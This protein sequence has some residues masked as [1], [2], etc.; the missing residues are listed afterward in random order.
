[1][2][3]DAWASL[4]TEEEGQ[5]SS[6]YRPDKLLSTARTN[7]GDLTTATRTQTVLGPRAKSALSQTQRAV[8]PRSS[9]HPIPSED[10]CQTPGQHAAT[11]S[12]LIKK[13]QTIHR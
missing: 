12:E 10:E 4:V 13:R 9:T 11:L 8:L 2:Q 5:P 3:S 1:M 6:W 7:K